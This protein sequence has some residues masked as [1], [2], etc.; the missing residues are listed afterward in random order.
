MDRR[1]KVSSLKRNS[2]SASFIKS[3]VKL[4][5]LAS[6]SIL[7]YHKQV[8]SCTFNL[9]ISGKLTDCRRT[10]LEV[11]LCS[12][13]KSCPSIYEVGEILKALYMSQII[14]DFTLKYSYSVT[15]V[16]ITPIIK[17]SK[18]YVRG[19][20]PQDALRLLENSLIGR[21]FRSVQDV[22]KLC[23]DLLYQEGI[24]YQTCTVSVDELEGTITIEANGK[25]EYIKD[26]SLHIDE[27]TM[28]K[29]VLNVLL[30]FKG[31]RFFPALLQKIKKEVSTKFRE[32]G[33][34]NFQ[35]EISFASQTLYADIK[36]GRKFAI[37][38]QIDEAEKL[39]LSD[40]QIRQELVNNFQ[41]DFSPS[42]VKLFVENYLKTSG[43][44]YANVSVSEVPVDEHISVVNIKV[45]FPA[46]IYLEEFK[47]N[48]LSELEEADIKSSIGVKERN[49]LTLFY[50]RYGLYHIEQIDEFISKVREFAKIHGFFDFK[51]KDVRKEASKDR[52][53][54]HIS[55]DEGT[56]AVIDNVYL[57]NFPDEVTKDFN[58]LRTPAFYDKEIIDNIRDSLEQT[59]RALGYDQFEVVLYED[60]KTKRLGD[61]YFIYV[62]S[63][64]KN[65]VKYVFIDAKTDHKFIKNISEID[66]GDILKDELIESAYDNLLA[67]RY[68]DDVKISAYRF[69]ASNN[70]TYGDSS[71]VVLD[72]REGKLGEVEVSGGISSVEGVRSSVDFTRRNILHWGID[73]S[74]GGRV[75]YWLFPFGR[76]IGPTF[77]GFRSEI[78]RRSIIAKLDTSLIFS[79][80]YES[81]FLYTVQKPFVA[82]FNIL[83]NFPS[84]RVSSSL[85]Y[86]FRELISWQGFSL[87][88]ESA[89]LNN[90]FSFSQGVHFK[91]GNLGGLVRNETIISPR[92]SDKLEISLEYYR[93]KTLWGIG[94]VLS[95]GRIFS[96]NIF[97]VPVDRRFFMGGTRGPRGY[98]EMS[99]YPDVDVRYSQKALNKFLLMTELFSPKIYF[100]RAY[101]FF[102]AGSAFYDSQMLQIFKGTGIGSFLE[103]PFGTFRLEMGYG[104]NRETFMIHFSFGLNR[105]TL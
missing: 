66:E 35:A 2:W 88:P 21:R 100:F 63:K 79:P 82:L 65:F 48:G 13:L 90:I 22:K 39:D 10:P 92:L 12:F 54:V 38:I 14:G 59:A 80:S 11:Q 99:I 47:I 52:L 31:E 41:G 58:A 61:I 43:I 16:F 55:V 78:S 76:E 104:I 37:F 98:K 84:G 64:T 17:A 95:V 93:M 28:E 96:D 57:V 15:S 101:L 77:F 8:Y 73:F 103:T 30:K 85:S 6:L 5:V 56:R 23:E 67:T 91:L 49:T 72:L 50:P 19:D 105:F 44:S 62:G 83:R 40:E 89:K 20:V 29:D 87:I 94:G 71:L 36:A 74:F 4:F 33:Y 75:A 24:Y 25:T 97:L 1:E 42:S 27:K 9:Y 51:I 86:E 70:Q 26:L 3:S 102:D 18:V 46:M 68:F 32:L 53:K 69:N 60:W 45:T 7:S 81:T 34:M